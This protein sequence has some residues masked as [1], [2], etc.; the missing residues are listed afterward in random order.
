MT[1]ELSG[2]TVDIIGTSIIFIITFVIQPLGGRFKR[3][4]CEEVM[5]VDFKGGKDFQVSEVLIFKRLM[6]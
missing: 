2:R 5:M 4:G 6:C 1:K 3:A